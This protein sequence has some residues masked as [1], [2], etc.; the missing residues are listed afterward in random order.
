MLTK[1]VTDPKGTAHSGLIA[2]YPLAGKTGTAEIKEKQGEKGRELGW[3]VAYNPQAADMIV[4]M[5]IEDSG[6]KDVVTRVKGFYE[7]R[8]ESGL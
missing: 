6:S 5:M 7:L 1:V 8:L 2:N 3:F 4:A